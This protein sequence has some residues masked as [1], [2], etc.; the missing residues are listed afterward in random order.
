MFEHVDVVVDVDVGESPLGPPDFLI[1]VRSRDEGV[2]GWGDP[3]TPS[4]LI[5]S[6]IFTFLPPI[7]ADVKER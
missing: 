6:L 1:S 7:I 4:P 5:F 3:L 2:K